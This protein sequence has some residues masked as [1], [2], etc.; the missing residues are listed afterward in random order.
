[1]A[2][3]TKKDIEDR[4]GRDLL[5]RIADKNGNGMVDTKAV[6]KALADAADEIDAHL[7]ARYELPLP[8]VPG[9]LVRL[10]VDMAVYFLAGDLRTD[11]QEARYANA[12]ALLRRI[13]EGKASLG[14]AAKDAPAQAQDMAVDAPD[15]IFSKDLLGRY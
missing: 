14:L 12:V 15:R 5:A 10:C 13:A 1:M 7:S 8:E 6:E 4:Y 11:E 3:A 9:L 2:Y